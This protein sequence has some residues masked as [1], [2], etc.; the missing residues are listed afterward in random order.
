MGLSAIVW[1][2]DELVFEIGK[3]GQL[4]V[5]D[6]RSTSAYSVSSVMFLLSITIIN[7]SSN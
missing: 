5:V 3:F 7:Q 2:S 6:Q 1:A 4:G